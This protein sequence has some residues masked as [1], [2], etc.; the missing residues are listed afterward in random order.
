MESKIPPAQ[1]WGLYKR[2]GGVGGGKGISDLRFEISYWVMSAS[3]VGEDPGWNPG[4]NEMEALAGP[5]RFLFFLV[6]IMAR[7]IGYVMTYGAFGW[8]QVVM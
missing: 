6:L 2:R 8:Y 5:G 3:R 4:L 1:D 7:M